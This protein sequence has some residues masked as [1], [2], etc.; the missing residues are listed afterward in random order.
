MW[1]EWRKPPVWEREEW[2]TMTWEEKMA[3]WKHHRKMS[4]LLGGIFI[5]AFI[6]SMVWF[7]HKGIFLE[8]KALFLA[9]VILVTMGICLFVGHR[10]MD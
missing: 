7:I 8:R 6:G 5:V 9:P 4:F 10:L 3:L 1:R 2:D